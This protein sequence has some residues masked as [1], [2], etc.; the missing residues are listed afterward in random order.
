MRKV[1]EL[2]MAGLIA[3]VAALAVGLFVGLLVHLALGGRIGWEDFNLPGLVEGF[4]FLVAFT[5]SLFVA[6]RAVRVPCS[7]LLTGGIVAPFPARRVAQ[8]VP[9]VASPAEGSSGRW[10]VLV[11][12]EKPVGVLG[13][14]SEIVP[15]EEA[16]VVEGDVAITELAPLF[17]QG[18]AVFVADGDRVHGVITREHYLKTVVT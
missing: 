3:F 5:L 2:R 18:E 17:W 4:L 15:W 13:L 1:R 7:T 12:G 11:E 10:A 14:G 16:P 8:P 9:L 6:K